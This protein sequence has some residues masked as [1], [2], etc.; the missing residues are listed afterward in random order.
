MI[1][2]KYQILKQKYLN[3]Y[4]ECI[5]DVLLCFQNDK[6]E[7]KIVI[8]PDQVPIFSN[9]DYS[10]KVSSINF[11]NL[12]DLRA[13][14]INT[15]DGRINPNF[16]HK[17]ET[18]F[19][20]KFKNLDSISSICFRGFLIISDKQG[21]INLFEKKFTKKYKTNFANFQVRYD[22][23][24]KFV[25]DSHLEIKFFSFDKFILSKIDFFELI[26]L[27]ILGD[28]SYRKISMKFWQIWKDFRLKYA[29]KN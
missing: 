12:S 17:F 14:F 18:P 28:S 27:K 25:I 6:L 21:N 11:K 23:F 24:N 9:S 3:E 26:L 20:V 29:K 16:F 8:S 22:D 19:F 5:S 15:I 4:P 10:R 13:S 2:K 7:N 1:M